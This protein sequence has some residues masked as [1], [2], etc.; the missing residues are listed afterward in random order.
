MV[1]TYSIL[2]IVGFLFILASL[3]LYALRTKDWSVF[4]KL[5]AEDEKMTQ[6]EKIMAIGG[7]L[8]IILGFVWFVLTALISEIKN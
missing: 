7:Y 1:A 3:F 2:Y 5:Y 6:L 4:K 8:L